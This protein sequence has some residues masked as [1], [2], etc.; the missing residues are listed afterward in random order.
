VLL[1]EYLRLK[2]KSPPGDPAPELAH[3]PC[4]Q[5][6]HQIK[7]M[8]LQFPSWSCCV[9]GKSGLGADKLMTDCRLLVNLP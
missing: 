4:K 5:A 7:L 3:P 6:K 8:K 9:L 2:S 1:N